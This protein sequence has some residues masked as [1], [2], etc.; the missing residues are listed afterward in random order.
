MVEPTPLRRNVARVRAL[1]VREGSGVER[2]D[3]L[4]AEEPMEIRVHGPGQEAVPIVVTMR[5]P[6]G[7]FELAA[8]FL[9]TEGLISGRDDV[10]RVSYCED[11]A[12]DE[13]HYNVVT[14]ELARPFDGEALRRSFLASSSCGICGKATLDDV[15]VHCAPVA[16][17]LEVGGDAI[18]AMPLA[19]RRAQRVFEETGGL[20]A[21]GLFAP[22]GK[23]LALR[24]DVGR[25]NAVDKIVGESLLA[26][27]LPLSDRV[28]QVSGRVG[29]EIVQK[30]ARAGVPVIS[31]VGAPSSLS[32]EAADRLGLT[33]VGFVRDGGFNVYAHP[34]RIRA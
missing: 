8:G 30:A 28:L 3:L 25:H 9:F 34:E 15:E 2:P 7:D 19:L 21:A 26:G 18:L 1:S 17:G 23:L 24:E 29:F 22:D 13:Q 11:L 27:S 10:R 32:V 31:A 14:V 6:G 20:H 5:T 4:A 16:P 33:L 12:P